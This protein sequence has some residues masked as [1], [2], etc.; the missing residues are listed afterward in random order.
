MDLKT[1]KVIAFALDA[2]NWVGV[3]GKSPG[4]LVALR[5][6]Y[7]NLETLEELWES[8]NPTVAAKL[9]NYELVWARAIDGLNAQLAPA[10]EAEAKIDDFI[11]SAKS[12]SVS[13]EA[14]EVPDVD[15]IRKRITG[16]QECA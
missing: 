9:R 1:A 5:E 13:I 11:Q 10:P 15:E 8:L 4:D 16:P 12:E 6:K 3:A 7:D 14:K 2:E